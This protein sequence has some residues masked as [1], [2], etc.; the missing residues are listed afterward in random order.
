MIV[1]A[2]HSKNVAGVVN[3]PSRIVKMYANTTRVAAEAAYC[4]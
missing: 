3:V 2:Y 4:A 1:R